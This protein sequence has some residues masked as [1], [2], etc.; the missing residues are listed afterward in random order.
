MIV[1][2]TFVS[3]GGDKAAFVASVV[4]LVPDWFEIGDLLQRVPGRT[5]EKDF[6]GNPEAP[7]AFAEKQIGMDLPRRLLVVRD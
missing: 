3:R 4:V 5:S 6:G 7:G 2:L 1:C